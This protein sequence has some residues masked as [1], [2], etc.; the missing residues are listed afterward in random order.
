MV[1]LIIAMG[2][3]SAITGLF[4][5]FLKRH[6]DKKES[7]REQRDANMEQLILFVM[8]NSRATNVLAKATAVAVQRIPDAKC[9]GDMKKALEEAAEIQ[10]EEKDFLIQQGIKHIFE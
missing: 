10:K 9:N 6:I 8:Q 7:I 5:W 1:Q 2:V 4:I 3:P